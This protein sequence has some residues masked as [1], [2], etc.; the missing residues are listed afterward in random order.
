[1]DYQHDRTIC[2]IGL[3]YVGLTLAIIMAEAGYTVWGVE[4]NR[5]FTDKIVTGKAHFHE[6]GLDERLAIQLQAGQFHVSNTLPDD[7]GISLYII[8]VGTPLGP[9]GKVRLDMVRRV[10]REIAAQLKDG[11]AVVLRSTVKIGT[12]RDIVLPILAETGRDFDIGFC[13]ERTLE[14][15]ALYE[16]THLPQIIGSTSARGSIRLAQVFNA[17]TPTVIRVRDPETAEMIKL[18][19][20]TSRDVGFAFAN[21]VARLCGAVGISASEVIT[22][23]KLGYARTQLPMPGPVGGPCLSKDSHIL[24]E[25]MMDR[26]VMPEIAAAARNINER[27]MIEVAEYL[28]GQVLPW[29]P[30]G[31]VKISMMGLAFKGQPETND[32]RGSTVIPLLAELRKLLPRATFRGYDP[33]VSAQDQ[34]ALG[35]TPMGDL[36]EA[37]D[38]A[39]LVIVHNNHPIFQGMPLSRL[40]R[41]LARPAIVYDFWNS[42]SPERLSLEDGVRYVALGSHPMRSDLPVLGQPPVLGQA[43]V[44]TAMLA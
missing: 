18:I 8:T 33:I 9:D 3:G 28:A 32:L 6:P 35:L 5:D 40:A 11:D 12:T 17:I 10:T 27:L 44:M 2:V 7:P 39:H 38:G 1:M 21:E 24:V 26:G 36:A 20:N 19:D 25:S 16:L 30:S 13:P 34:V 29:Y 4:L 15:R 22:F 14:G 42:F 31:A 41:G 23:G 43:E 37:F